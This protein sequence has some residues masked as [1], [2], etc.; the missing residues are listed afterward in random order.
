MVGTPADVAL[1]GTGYKFVSAASFVA[2]SIGVSLFPRLV[3]AVESQDAAGTNGVIKSEIMAVTAFFGPACIVGILVLPTLFQWLYSGNLSSTGWIMVVLMP[4]LYMSS[5]NIGTKFTLNVMSL[6]WYDTASVLIG[7]AT[8][9]AVFFLAVGM[10][11]SYR[12]AVAWV[13]GEAMMFA[14]KVIVLRLMRR[15]IDLHVPVVATTF[16]L[17]VLT[18]VM[19]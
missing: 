14:V 16:A 19:R 18:A 3:R 11:I 6:N 2:T 17:L 13:A 8:F 12:T 10:P 9:S 15:D 1:F 7:L 5:I 4:G